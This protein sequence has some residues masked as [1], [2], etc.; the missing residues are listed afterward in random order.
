MAHSGEEQAKLKKNNT[1]AAIEYALAGRWRDAVTANK[2]ILDLFPDDIEALNRLGRAHME[3]GEY[4]EAQRAYRR[5]KELDPYNSIA[6]RNLKRLNVL[7]TSG[8]GKASVEGD[9]IEP[10]VF[11]EEIGKAGVVTLVNPAPPQVLARVDAGDKAQ[12]KPGNG[13]LTVE[14]GDGEYLGIVEVRHAL[15][16]AKLISGGNRYSATIVSADENK[17]AVMIREIYQHPSQSG[18]LSFPARHKASA[19]KPELEDPSLDDI[20][21]TPEEEP[22]LVVEESDDESYPD[23]DEEEDEEDEEELEV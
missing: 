13:K 5:S 3:L 14:T 12:L 18:Q 22:E 6:D 4:T 21:A 17:V 8:P 7:S 2:A 15:R 10:K 19:P 9:R 11:I 16:L 1:Q 23:E 20:E